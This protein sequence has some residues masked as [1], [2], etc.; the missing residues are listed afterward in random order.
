MEFSDP[1]LE[2]LSAIARPH[3]ADL[4]QALFSRIETIKTALQEVEGLDSDDLQRCEAL[5]QVAEARFYHLEAQLEQD[6]GSAQS[7]ETAIAQLERSLNSEIQELEG[8]VSEKRGLLRKGFN[9]VMAGATVPTSTPIVQLES[10]H[11]EAD[12]L[13]V[14]IAHLLF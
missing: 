13:S 8:L 4:K 11:I 14:K 9:A 6:N 7:N 5:M 12:E 3:I 2:R 1:D 10:S